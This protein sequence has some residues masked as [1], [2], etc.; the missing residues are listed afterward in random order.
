MP[1]KVKRS[2]K[3]QKHI[4]YCPLNIFVQIILKLNQATVKQ[5]YKGFVCYAGEEENC[6]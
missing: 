5:T 4:K 6:M 1:N 2:T 3:N